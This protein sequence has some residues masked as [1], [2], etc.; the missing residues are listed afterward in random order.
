[1]L[2]LLLLLL[3]ISKCVSDVVCF[4]RKRVART[5]KNKKALTVYM[6]RGQKRERLYRDHKH[7]HE[8]KYLCVLW[9]TA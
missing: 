9:H 3:L 7:A 2:L 8:P 4:I 6:K 1:M 5:L